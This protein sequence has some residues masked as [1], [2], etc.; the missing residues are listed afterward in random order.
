MG[1]LDSVIFGVAL[2]VSG[3]FD[4]NKKQIKHLHM[5]RQ[6]EQALVPAEIRIWQILL[7]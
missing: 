3:A 4:K 5:V 1:L 2:G 6:R 7:D